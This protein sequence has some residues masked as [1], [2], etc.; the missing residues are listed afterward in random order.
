MHIHSYIYIYIYRQ[1]RL[2]VC[3]RTGKLLHWNAKHL[4]ICYHWIED[5]RLKITRKTFL[6]VVNPGHTQATLKFFQTLERALPLD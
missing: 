3:L 4:T 5:S 2:K 1:K 6:K